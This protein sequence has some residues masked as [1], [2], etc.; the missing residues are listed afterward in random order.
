MT[1]EVPG[2]H[3]LLPAYPNPF[4][5]ST[6]FSLVVATEQQVRLDVYDVSGRHIQTMHEGMLSANVQHAFRFE[7][8]D[9]PGGLYVIRAVGETFSDSHKVMLAK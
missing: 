9:L 4:N 6:Q 8:D 1:I 7:A 5:P 3:A 2:T